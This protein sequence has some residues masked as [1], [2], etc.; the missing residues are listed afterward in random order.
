[1]LSAAIF[2]WALVLETVVQKGLD[3]VLTR[4]NT[5]VIKGK[6]EERK[7]LAV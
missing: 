6:R 1:M 4:N 2:D 5:K 3:G 7:N